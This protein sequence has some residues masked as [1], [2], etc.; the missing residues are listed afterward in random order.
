VK[1]GRLRV[2]TLLLFTASN[3]GYVHHDAVGG[4]NVVTPHPTMAMDAGVTRA[5]ASAARM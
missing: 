1:R 4:M 2:R 3:S 5:E